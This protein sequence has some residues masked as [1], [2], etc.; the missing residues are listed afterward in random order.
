MLCSLDVLV[1]LFFSS[2]FFV[3]V[4]KHIPMKY[5]PGF[6]RSIAYSPAY[7][8]F[9]PTWNF[10]APN[11]G[12]HTFHLLYRDQSK[13]MRMSEWH[14][15]RGEAQTEWLRAIW[16]PSK[17]FNKA[18]L[19]IVVELA[20]VVVNSRDHP[21]MVKISIPYITVLTYVSSIPRMTEQLATQFMLVQS[22]PATGYDMLFISDIHQL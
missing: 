7:S 2:W 9:I 8:R 19:D 21:A 10:F 13:D 22:S 17:A 5:M 4:I 3:T 14:E 12:K 1:I 11:P 18:T 20:Q 16:N 15:V 6:W